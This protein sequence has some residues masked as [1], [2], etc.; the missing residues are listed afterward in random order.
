MSYADRKGGK[1]RFVMIIKFMETITVFCL[2]TDHTLLQAQFRGGFLWDSFVV[3]RLQVGNSMGG[4]C[5]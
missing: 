5:S 4:P 2:V 3:I 1:E